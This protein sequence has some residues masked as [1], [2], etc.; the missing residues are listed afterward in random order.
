MRYREEE[1]VIHIAS[2]GD[3]PMTTVRASHACATDKG[4]YPWLNAEVCV[5]RK[6]GRMKLP[7]MTSGPAVARFIREALPEIAGSAQEHVG[8]LAVDT[9]NRP[10]GVAIINKGAGS[11]SLADPAAT[12]RLVLLLPATGFVL[13]HNHPSEDVSPSGDDVELTRRMKTA[14]EYVGL[15]FLDHLVLTPENY[16]SFVEHGLTR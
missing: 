15:R 3:E 6:G 5:H 9:R 16:Y 11:Q 2:F 8:I 7:Q 4:T 14:A 12:L 1:E 13:F 10:V